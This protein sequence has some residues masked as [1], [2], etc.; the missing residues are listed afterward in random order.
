MLIGIYGRPTRDNTSA[1][2]QKLFNKLEELEAQVWIEE[3]FYHHIKEK[4]SVRMP[5]QFF[6]LHLPLP[7]KLDL[8]LSLGGDGTFLETLSFIRNSGIPVLGINTGRLGFLAMVSAEEIVPA[9]EAVN[10]KNYTVEERIMLKLHSPSKLFEIDYAMNELTVM[11][12]ESSSMMTIHA[13]VDGEYLN[14][15]FADGLIIATPTGSTAYS[16]SC[17]GPIVVPGTGNFIINPIAP[18]NLNVRPLIVSSNS[19][20]RLRVEGRNPSYLLSLDSRT[21]SIDAH[22]EIVIKRA[23]FKYAVAKLPHQHFFKTIRNKLMWGIDRRTNS[24]F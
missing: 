1:D 4:I 22:T 8:V 15:Y 19:E 17:G 9:L 14:S 20:I 18:H 12:K 11:K 23:E 3:K 21:T 7:V 2:I 5:V 6:S 24:E 16:L 13:S 10:Q